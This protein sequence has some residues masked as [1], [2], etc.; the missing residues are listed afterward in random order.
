[1][2]PARLRHRGCPRSRPGEPVGSAP[3]AATEPSPSCLHRA[4]VTELPSP[5]ASPAVRRQRNRLRAGR[6]RSTGHCGQ[7]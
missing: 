4:A 2:L 5:S 6:I 1:M 7:T 3:A